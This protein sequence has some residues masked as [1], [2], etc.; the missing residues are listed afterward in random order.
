MTQHYYPE[1]GWG[2]VVLAA[3]SLAHALLGGT[4]LSAG[5]LVWALRNAFSPTIPTL[6][7]GEKGPSTRPRSEWRG[8]GS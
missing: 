4:N 2:W 7:A 1:G 6:H 5:I 8:A 3:A